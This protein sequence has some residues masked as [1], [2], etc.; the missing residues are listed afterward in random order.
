MVLGI[1]SK[2]S[3]VG[4]MGRMLKDTDKDM[5]AVRISKELEICEVG[6]EAC[7]ERNIYPIRKEPTPDPE[8][9][10][11]EPSSQEDDEGYSRAT[12][13]ALS[14]TVGVLACLFIGLSVY[15]GYKKFYK[16]N[17]GEPE[18]LNYA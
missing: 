3:P 9:E 1:T 14:I 4:R 2:M 15:I 18:N 12:V 16:H 17:H 11:V 8:P 10:I 7:F 6:D 13:V 5:R